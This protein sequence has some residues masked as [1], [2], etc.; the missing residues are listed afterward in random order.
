[1]NPADLK[2]RLLSQATSNREKASKGLR[3]GGLMRTEILH[4]QSVM[5]WVQIGLRVTEKSRKHHENSSSSAQVTYASKAD[6]ELKAPSTRCGKG[7]VN[8]LHLEAPV[9]KTWKRCGKERLLALL[10]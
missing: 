9:Y 2:A 6:N 5:F 1:M 4:G 10:G 7:S 3:L 8:E